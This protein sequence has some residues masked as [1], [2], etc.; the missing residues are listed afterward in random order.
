MR[1]VLFALVFSFL[2]AAPAVAGTQD[3]A[4]VVV[5]CP[6]VAIKGDPCSIGL[7]LSCTDAQVQRY[8]D[9]GWFAFLYVARADADAGVGGV[10]CGTGFPADLS[11]WDWDLCAD[12]ETPT[13]AWPDSGSGNR[14]TWDAGTNCQREVIGTDGVH[15]VAGVFYISSY[16]DAVFEITPNTA[17]GETA[18]VVADCDG[19]ESELSAP[20]GRIGFGDVEGYNPCAEDVPVIPST[21]GRIKANYE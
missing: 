17:A 11:V 19:A 12:G 8:V 9:K 5:E 18:L 3:E 21:W 20:G 7:T 16:V 4:V 6:Y 1:A 2:C 10:S 13:G 14:I 15:A